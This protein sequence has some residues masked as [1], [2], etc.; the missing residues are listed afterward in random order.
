MKK[1]DG[2]VECQYCYM[3]TEKND[4]LPELDI[5]LLL[6]NLKSIN[7]EEFSNQYEKKISFFNDTNN[8][9]N[10]K[11]RNI[12]QFLIKF[13]AKEKTYNNNETKKVYKRNYFEFK[14]E[15]FLPNNGDLD[16]ATFKT[17][18]TFKYN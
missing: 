18:H 13:I 7:D 14:K 15:T 1:N 2:S 12:V 5:K 4:L 6:S 3:I 17:Q 11:L 8:K 10:H 9:N 16:G